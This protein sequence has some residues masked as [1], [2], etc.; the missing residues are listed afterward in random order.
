[1]GVERRLMA[2]GGRV[3]ANSC[4]PLL[5]PPNRSILVKFGVCIKFKPVSSSLCHAL[6][7]CSESFQRLYRRTESHEKKTFKSMV[8]CLRQELK[9]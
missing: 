2:S 5:L 1:M 6:K 7:E 4:S 3:Y 8:F 9:E